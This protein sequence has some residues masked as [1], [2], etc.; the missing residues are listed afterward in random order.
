MKYSRR[1]RKVRSCSEA[2]FKWSESP[3]LL[4]GTPFLLPWVARVV[5]NFYGFQLGRGLRSDSAPELARHS[6]WNSKLL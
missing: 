2:V 1:R 3:I 5:I 6:V 4:L